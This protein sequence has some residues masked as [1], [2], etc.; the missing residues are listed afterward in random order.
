[1][2]QD[3]FLVDATMAENIALGVAPGLIDPERVKLAA[4]VAELDTFIC[5]ELANGYDTEIGERGV[6][7]SG[8]QRQRVGLA[9]ALYRDADLIVLDEATSALDN[10][11]E[12]AV[13]KSLEALHRDK[14]VIVVAHRLS[15][16]RYCDRIVVME[17]G[18]ITGLGTYEDLL[19]GNPAFQ[20]L[21]AAGQPLN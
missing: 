8:G 4:Q 6:R 18:R 11:T 20:K 2:P 13:I 16:V 14:T 17:S 9:R 15:T 12:R 5:E 7:L 3:I 1:M 21:E 19:S 10:V